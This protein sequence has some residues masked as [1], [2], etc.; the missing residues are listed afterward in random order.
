MYVTIVIHCCHNSDFAKAILS[1]ATDCILGGALEIFPTVD[2]ISLQQ[3]KLSLFEKVQQ[4]TG[5]IST[6]PKNYNY[7]KPPQFIT[8]I[9]FMH[10]E[11]FDIRDKIYAD[12]IQRTAAIFSYFDYISTAQSGKMRLTFFFIY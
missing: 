7:K 5:E 3:E 4:N 10:D 2:V 12:N 8:S 1:F 11:E 9:E 6:L